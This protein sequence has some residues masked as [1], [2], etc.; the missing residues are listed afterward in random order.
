MAVEGVDY[1][2]DRPDL[3]D[4]YAAGKRFIVR[5]L[6]DEPSKNLTRAEADAAAKAGLWL[7]VVWEASDGQELPDAAWSA[8]ESV[9]QAKALAVPAGRPI[10]FAVDWDAQPSEY[11]EIESF[12]RAYGSKLAPYVAGVY[13]GEK[14]CREM[15]N[16]GAVK[17]FWQTYAWSSAL[18]SPEPH[19]HQYKN[20]TELCGGLVD[21]DRGYGADYGQWQPNKLPSGSTTSPVTEPEPEP[22]PEPAPKP[23]SGG[24]YTAP[25]WAYPY[26]SPDHY[27]DV[28]GD[29]HSHGGYHESE[30]P[31]VKWIQVR[32]QELGYAPAGSGWA[33]GV[34]EQ[35]TVDAVS[36]WQRARHSSTTSLYGQVWGDDWENLETDR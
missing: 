13:G 23:P 9:T 21:L 10:Y 18:L 8:T 7:A 5:Y 11:D 14:V 35:P 27:G 17:W 34:F 1:S 19:L 12:L 16:R 2:W 24:V 30:Q 25:P 29:A 20:N 26:T 22:A 31:G 4:L 36:D 28:A 6:S 33:D 3:D 15:R 32:M